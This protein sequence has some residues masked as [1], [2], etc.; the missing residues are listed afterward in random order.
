MTPGLF[1]DWRQEWRL[2]RGA[3][4]FVEGLLADPGTDDVA[5]LATLARVDEDRARWELRY[6]RRA[7]GMLVAQ[8]DALDDRTGSEVARELASAMHN[9]PHI[10]ADMVKIADRQLNERL[11][12]YREVLTTRRP[13]EGTGKRLGRVLLRLTGWAGPAEDSQ[14]EQVGD[15]MERFLTQSNDA[16]RKAFGTASLPEDLPPSAARSGKH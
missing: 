10:A 2:R 8:R 3:A 4:S 9:D 5:K 13:E 11:A 15:V 7:L 6:A 14:L 1:D 12:A 16:L